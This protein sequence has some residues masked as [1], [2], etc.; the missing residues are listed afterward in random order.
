[1][2]SLLRSAT[3]GVLGGAA[4]SALRAGAGAGSSGSGAAASAFLAP[5]R[6]QVL[7]APLAPA[8]PFRST[9]VVQMGRRSAKIALRKV[10]GWFVD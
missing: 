9:P 7:S 3:H 10:G 4:A 5:L 6:P 8:R 1:M 2:M